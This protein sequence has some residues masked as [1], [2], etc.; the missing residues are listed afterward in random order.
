MAG[1]PD[2]E[3]ST[4]GSRLVPI[5]CASRQAALFQAGDMREIQVPRSNFTV[6]NRVMDCDRTVR[7]GHPFTNR[8]PD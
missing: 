6:F 7:V 4:N 1:L 3:R 8:T 5:Q 2:G